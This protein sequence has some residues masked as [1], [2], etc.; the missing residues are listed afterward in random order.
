MALLLRGLHPDTVRSSKRMALIERVTLAWEDL[1]TPERRS[2]YDFKRA[3]R[4]TQPKK[5]AKSKH[6][7]SPVGS[8]GRVASHRSPALS[9]GSAAN[10]QPSYFRLAGMVL[11]KVF[12]Q[13]F[14][15]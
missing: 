1:K 13:V 10:R 9:P 8:K 2:A 14:Y 12:W 15:R 4:D 7:R 11:R 6:G 5:P 3:S